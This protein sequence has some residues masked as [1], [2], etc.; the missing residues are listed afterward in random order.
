[1]IDVLGP[2]KRRRRSIQEKIAIVQQSFEPGMTVSLITQ[3][4]G[5]VASQLFLWRKQYQEG[6]LSAVASGS[7]VRNCMPWSVGRRAGRIVDESASLMIPKRWTVSIQL[8]A[9]CLRM[10][11]VGCGHCCSSVNLQYR[12]RN[13]RIQGKRLSG[14]VTSGGAL[15]ASSSTVIMAKNGGSRSYWTAVIVKPCTGRPV[16]VDMIAK[17]YRT[18]CRVRWSIASTVAFRRRQWRG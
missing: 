17:P 11:I 15:T 4:H 9:I 14:K 13:G 8:S 12:P 5:V 6:S 1:M 2:E 7:H 16:P 10:V 3:Q 18:S